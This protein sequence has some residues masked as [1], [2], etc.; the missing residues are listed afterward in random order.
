MGDGKH[1]EVH[2]S[3]QQEALGNSVNHLLVHAALH[4][5]RGLGTKMWSIPWV[6]KLV[7][8]HRGALEADAGRVP[9]M[10]GKALGAGRCGHPRVL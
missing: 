1:F 5:K 3:S 7:A 2:V 10:G 4:A 9:F 6:K 8:H